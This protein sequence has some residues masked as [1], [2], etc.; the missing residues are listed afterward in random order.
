MTYTVPSRPHFS[1]EG[2]AKPSLIVIAGRHP[3]HYP[4]AG[5]V[6][7]ATPASPTGTVDHLTVRQ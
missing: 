1:H 2:C 7:L 4:R 3:I 5:V 6:H